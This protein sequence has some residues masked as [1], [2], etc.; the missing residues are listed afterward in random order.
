VNHRINAGWMKWK[1]ASRVLCD[2][3]IPIKLKGKFYKIVIRLAMF[4]RIECWAI[5]KQHVHK[6]NV[7]DIKC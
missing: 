2:R 5:N 1:N 4:Y 7:V 6:M 3:R